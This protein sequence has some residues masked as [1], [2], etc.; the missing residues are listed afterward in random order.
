MFNNLFLRFSYFERPQLS[1]LFCNNVAISVKFGGLIK[2]RRSSADYGGGGGYCAFV[3]TM[4]CNS[5]N[6]R[7]ILAHVLMSLY[8]N[9]P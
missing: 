6:G 1:H 8:M 9:H 5:G 3:E 2:I 7:L 4:F